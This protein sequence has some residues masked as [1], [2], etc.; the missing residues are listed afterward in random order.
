MAQ[1]MFG[2]PRDIGR[3]QSYN[4]KAAV[5]AFV[6]FGSMLLKKS[7]RPC[8]HLPD[9]NPPSKTVIGLSVATLGDEGGSAD[10]SQNA[11]LLAQ[12]TS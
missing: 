9:R 4:S 12:I 7:V 6:R 2:S 10:A 1:P 3:T 11:L 8:D 5:L